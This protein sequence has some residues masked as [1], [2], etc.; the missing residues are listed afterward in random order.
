MAATGIRERT[1]PLRVG[2]GCWRQ[3]GR[4]W[5]IRCALSQEAVSDGD[6]GTD[7]VLIFRPSPTPTA[8]YGELVSH[9]S[10]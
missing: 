3:M 8:T 2:S 10:C 4:S 6:I 1:T 9:H 5:K 7:H